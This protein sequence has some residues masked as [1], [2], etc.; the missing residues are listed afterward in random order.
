ML[1]PGSRL[2]PYV[3]AGRIG[4]GGMGEVYRARDTRLGRDVAL[5]TLPPDLARDAERRARFE[6]EARAV[7]SLNHPHIVTLHSLEEV[8]GILFLTMELVEGETVDAAVARARGDLTGLLRIASAVAD[9]VAYAHARGILHRDLKPSNLMVTREGRVKVLDFGLAKLREPIGGEASRSS[10]TTLPGGPTGHHVVLGTPAY[11]SPEQ[12]E[13]R[14]VDERCDLFSL[15]VVLYELATG[16]RPFRG[17]STIAVLSA[18]LRET[19]RPI[20]EL[21]PTV[22]PELARIVMRCLAKEPG[23]R[24][25]SARELRDDLDEVRQRA[26]A[27]P[28]AAATAVHPPATPVRRSVAVLPFL[29]LSPDPENEYFADGITEDVIAQLS[30]MRSLKVISR[31]SAM[32]FKRREQSLREIAAKLGVATLVEG[33]VRRAGD[34][35]RIVAE[36]IDAESDAHLWVETFDRRLTDIFEIQSEVALR[37]AEGLRGE[38]STEERLRVGGP[39]PVDLEAYQFLLKGRQ[40]RLRYTEAGLQSAVGHFEQA[41]ARDPAYA[42]AYQEIAIAFL[43]MALGFGLGSLRPREAHARAKAAVA[44]ALELDPL[45]GEAHGTHG[46]LRF[47][48]DFDWAGAEESFRRALDLSP[49]SSFTLDLF[50][51]LLSAQERYEE[52][53]AV[54]R[55]SR[56]LDPLTVVHTSDLAT[57]LIRA[58]RLEEAMREARH[59]IEMDESFP[60]GH[61][62]LGWALLL[63]GDREAGLGEIGR[64]VE[65]SPG[66]DLLLAQLG[67]AEAMAGRPERAR[68]I[69]D[70]LQRRAEERPVL[71]YHR[72]YVHT[73]LGEPERAIDLLEAAAEERGGGIYGIKGSF[74]FTPLRGHPR[75]HALLRR[76]NLAG[77]DPRTPAP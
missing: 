58:A 51:L 11:M 1:E 74:L 68:R 38:L 70:E 5:K 12:V 28:A 35:V 75:F 72:A 2:G 64:A 13:G 23:E 77:E 31:T 4:A 36:L 14:P 71:P 48:A 56:E 61:S 8:E 22:P 46:A 49:G 43:V 17:R 69:L 39:A 7:A 57:T 73:G 20:M 63:A 21:N 45:S 25:A 37:I 50:G 6:R 27:Q 30:K 76:M 53:L 47:M 16:E 32:R 26:E 66:S 60:I 19:P 9:A 40:A 10:A 44:R 15:G 54:Q 67:E 3:I 18:V 33:S 52:A 59:A 65:L 62:A 24:Y 55:R 42:A 41:L 34:R 29:N